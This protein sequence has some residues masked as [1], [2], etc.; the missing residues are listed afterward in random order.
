MIL[1]RDQ[2]FEAGEISYIR[3]DSKLSKSIFCRLKYTQS[4]IFH[5]EKTMG[6]LYLT[7]AIVAEVVATGSLK[8]SKQ[9]TEL[10]PSVLVLIGYAISFY[11]LSLV[12]KTI[13]VGIAY[14]MWSGLGVIL[15]SLIGI[16][17]FDQKLDAPAILGMV[18]I[19]SGVV[20][21]NVFSSTVKH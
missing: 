14:A 8:S 20:I 7:I 4:L 16:K 17:F 2:T 10:V 13:P 18:L 1:K 11:S 19:I 12:L 5:E 3:P 15:I 6:Y 21:M 9:F